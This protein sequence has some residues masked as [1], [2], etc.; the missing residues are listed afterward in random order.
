MLII[1]VGVGIIV[2][3]M[4]KLRKIKTPSHT[5]SGRAGYKMHPVSGPLRKPCWLPLH[6]PLLSVVTDR[7]TYLHQ[8]PE[9]AG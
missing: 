7:H 2:S 8:G 3:K 6:R 9:Q 1:T 5:T 4:R